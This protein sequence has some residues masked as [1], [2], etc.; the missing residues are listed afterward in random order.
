M[1]AI[2]PTITLAVSPSVGF[3]H[4]TTFSIHGKLNGMIS[5]VLT[6]AT[7]S[8]VVQ[9]LVSNSVWTNLGSSITLDGS[10]SFSY[11]GSL[12]SATTS[13][14]VVFTSS[15][16]AVWNSYIGGGTSVFL[17]AS[18]KPY[19]YVNAPSIVQQSGGTNTTFRVTVCVNPDQNYQN[20]FGVATNGE[21]M[22]LING[23]PVNSQAA[24]GSSGVGFPLF[25]QNGGDGNIVYSFDVPT[26][27]L[28]VGANQIVGYYSGGFRTNITWLASTSDPI[29]VTLVNPSQ[30]SFHGFGFVGFHSQYCPGVNK[31]F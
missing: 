14:R 30:H 6:P 20:I 13:I 3:F 12:L 18:T 24:Y 9:C 19:L 26:S 25:V 17:T 21:I 5:G 28:S 31:G 11:T 27:A 16:T 4:S 7:G 29:T 8:V 22:L 23:V 15:N 10:G 2:N 1:A